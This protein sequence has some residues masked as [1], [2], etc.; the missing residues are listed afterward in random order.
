MA[1]QVPLSGIRAVVFD[2]DGTLI[3]VHRTWGPAMAGALLDLVDDPTRRSE[4]AAAIGVDLTR[5]NSPLTPR[6][7]RRAMTSS[8]LPPDPRGRRRAVPPDLRGAAVRPRRWHLRLC[9]GVG[10]LDAPP[11]GCWIGLATNDAEMSARQ[12]LTGLGWLHRFES[13]IGYDSGFGAKPGSGM[14]LESAE[15]AGVKPQE[16]V[17]V[18]DTDTDLRTVAA[19]GC[20][21]SWSMRRSVRSSRRCTWRR[22]PSCRPCSPESYRFGGWRR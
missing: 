4:A 7:L 13:V 17:F 14:L 22:W 9:Q 18:G 1:E 19:A 16:L 10:A 2:K 15:R 3:D 8:S 6:S 21:V 12:Q 5:T 20:P 11:H